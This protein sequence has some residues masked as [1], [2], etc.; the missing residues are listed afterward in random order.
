[1]YF[2][3]QGFWAAEW[4][5]K[6]P[7]EVMMILGTM[8]GWGET[9]QQSECQVRGPVAEQKSMKGGTLKM[10]VDCF[11]ESMRKYNARSDH[12]RW[13]KSALFRPCIFFKYSVLPPPKSKGKQHKWVSVLDSGGCVSLC[14]CGMV[15]E[16]KRLRMHIC[17][18]LPT[19]YPISILPSSL[20][21]E[22]KF[23]L[24]QQCAMPSLR[25]MI[26]PSQ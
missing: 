23:C 15:C 2:T 25:T 7:W 12:G 1:M 17:G 14:G 26:G 3:C 5:G 8:Q 10:T 20:P 9:S 16:T 21:P 6:L 22:T 18:R 24:G 4:S 13:A 11:T 19:T